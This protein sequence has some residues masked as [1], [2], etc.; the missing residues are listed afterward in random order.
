MPRPELLHHASQ[1]REMLQLDLQ[2]LSNLIRDVEDIHLPDLDNDSLI[3]A[4]IAL[5]RATD[6]AKLSPI[7][8]RQWHDERATAAQCK[9][10]VSALHWGDALRRRWPYY[11]LSGTSVLPRLQPD[12]WLDV[13]IESVLALAPHGRS[14]LF[15]HVS[16]HIPQ[17]TDLYFGS[18]MTSADERA[19][20]AQRKS[21][22]SASAL[23]ECGF[24]AD[25]HIVLRDI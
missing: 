20:A 6:D 10:S 23:A 8:I 16:L 7:H 4:A 12:N 15:R 25:G 2:R 18:G 22:V 21:S 1:K 17:F 11:G 14:T 5:Q 24:V 3:R 19:A 9:T 13:A